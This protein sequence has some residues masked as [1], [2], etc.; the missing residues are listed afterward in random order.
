MFFKRKNKDH[1]NVD[2]T[3]ELKLKEYNKIWTKFCFFDESGSLDPKTAPFFTVDLIKC[4]QNHII[5]IA[6]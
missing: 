1:D 4:S 5:C 3:G 6:N 2:S